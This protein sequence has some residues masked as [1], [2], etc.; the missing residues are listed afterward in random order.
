MRR[1]R[2]EAVAADGTHSCRAGTIVTRRGPTPTPFGVAFAMT[3]SMRIG[4]ALILGVGS[5]LAQSDSGI[6]GGFKVA[7]DAILATISDVS[8]CADVTAS[9]LSE[10]TGD[11]AAT[12]NAATQHSHTSITV[13]SGDFAGLT[14][15]T[16]LGVVDMGNSARAGNVFEDLLS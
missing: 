5:D 7:Q 1:G 10:I 6:G 9:R 3:V 12:G 8:D 11:V 13:Q 2:Q 14:E 16:G 4:V 15:L